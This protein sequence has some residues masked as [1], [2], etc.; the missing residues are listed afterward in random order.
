MRQGEAPGLHGDSSIK[1]KESPLIGTS[2]EGPVRSSHLRTSLKSR[3]KAIKVWRS[4]A[5][6]M[7]I[8]KDNGVNRRVS[9]RGLDY[10]QSI[11]DDCAGWG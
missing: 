10:C 8:R 5:K 11:E 4:I 2:S 6:A 3:L 1:H 7:I 9:Q